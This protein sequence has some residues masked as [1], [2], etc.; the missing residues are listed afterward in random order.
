MSISDVL[1]PLL[2]KLCKALP[3]AHFVCISPRHNL[4]PVCAVV[5]FSSQIDMYIWLFPSAVLAL[6]G[7]SAI[8]FFAICFAKVCC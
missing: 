1:S 5:K 7:F 2:L 6:L 4:L 8:Q 3:L